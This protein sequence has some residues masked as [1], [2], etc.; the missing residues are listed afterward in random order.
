MVG[1]D[2]RLEP[3][4]PLAPMTDFE[5]VPAPG[6]ELC[7]A[8]ARTD[9]TNPFYTSA[10]VSY[11]RALGDD[12]WIVLV[13][14]GETLVTGC[15]AFCRSGRISRSLEITSMPRLGDAAAFWS[16]LRAYCKQR[17]VTELLVCTFASPAG[18]IPP[19]HNEIWRRPRVEYALG[20]LGPDLWKDIRKGHLSN[21]KKGRKAGLALK[22]ATDYEACAEHARLI[23]ASMSRRL[24]R[25]ERVA[26]AADAKAYWPL[27]QSGTGKLFQAVRDGHVLSSNLILLS[28]K[29]GY[30]H[31]QG[32]SPEGMAVGASHFLLFQIACAL[33]ESGFET[34]NLGGTDQLDSGLERSKDGFGATTSR[35]ALEAAAFS[36]EPRLVRLLKSAGRLVTGR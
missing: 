21:I 25:G 2:H 36:L 24:N 17:S 29:G 1:Q 11:R 6:P 23:D 5:V 12:P 3:H 15:T 30:N 16:H 34:L 22:V 8:L 18:A 33:R 27:L 19:L 13:R 9:R 20:L 28:E 14:S 26:L 32:T 31:S 7:A 4:V 10:Y 35:V